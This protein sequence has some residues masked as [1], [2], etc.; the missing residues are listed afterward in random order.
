MPSIVTILNTNVITG[1]LVA[2]YCSPS[3]L[4]NFVCKGSVRPTCK[5]ISLNWGWRFVLFFS[6][7]IMI[8]LALYCNIDA[9]VNLGR[10]T[11][12]SSN[13]NKIFLSS[14]VSIG[15]FDWL[16]GMLICY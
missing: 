5:S 2:L 15:L 16:L 9:Y 4:W 12:N 7:T 1:L 3:I 14:D 10:I 6:A 8:T 11:T 13:N